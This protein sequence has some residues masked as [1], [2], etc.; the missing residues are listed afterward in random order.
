MVYLYCYVLFCREDRKIDFYHESNL[1]EIIC[2]ASV[3]PH[4]PGELCT[5]E[6]GML[7]YLDK[8][9]NLRELRWLD[10][11]GLF[12]N[13]LK[14]IATQLSHVCEMCYTN[15]GDQDLLVCTDGSEINAYNSGSA[16]IEWNFKNQ[17]AEM[18]IEM[19]PKGLATTN[20]GLLFVSD[21]V[22][23]FIQVFS[24]D[25]GDYLGPL[26][27]NGEQG[28]GKPLLVRWCHNTSSLIVGH[29]KDHAWFIS[30]VKVQ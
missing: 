19:N 9:K 21:D 16:Q 22:H 11:R 24:V 13:P 23:G 27:K 12:P 25:G 5:S 26:I 28:L 8:S 3:A 4:L 10:C 7:M 15:T 20:E 2:S 14:A 18:V 30:V 17:S 29:F 1:N 6:S